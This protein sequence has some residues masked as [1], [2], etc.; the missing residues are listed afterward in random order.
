MRLRHLLPTTAV[1]SW[2]NG[3]VA[4]RLPTPDTQKQ[5]LLPFAPIAH[6]HFVA[7]TECHALCPPLIL[8][9][10]YLH[11]ELHLNPI[12]SITL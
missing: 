10:S 9:N 6:A 8:F 1:Q 7:F 2:H 12:T 5:P 11:H 4:T 3:C